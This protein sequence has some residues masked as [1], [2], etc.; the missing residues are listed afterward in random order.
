MGNVLMM[1]SAPART[2]LAKPLTPREFEVASLLP[3]SNKAIAYRL[4]ISTSTVRVHMTVAMDK[5]GA[6]NRTDLALIL[7]TQTATKIAA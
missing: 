1:P 7:V 2:Q 6:Q 3:L 4:G 5:M